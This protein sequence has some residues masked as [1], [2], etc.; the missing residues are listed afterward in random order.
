MKIKKIFL[1]F[2]SVLSIKAFSNSDSQNMLKYF[3]NLDYFKVFKN[4][5]LNGPRNTFYTNGNIKTK[6]FY[7]DNKKV[8]KWQYFYEDGTLKAE[9]D[10]LVASMN[11][12]AYIKNYD[13]KGIIF[14]EGKL[15][16]EEMVSKWIYYDENAKKSHILNFSTGDIF[17][18]DDKEKVVFSINEK[19]LSEKLFQVE[20]ELINDRD[21]ILKEK[22]IE[23]DL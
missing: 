5:S 8:G 16:N 9:I 1:I 15:I 19:E 12:E 2:I 3:L 13:S 11:E 22:L 20:L 4:G 21:K 17:V 23:E 7:I 10:F 6:E 14:N 18:L